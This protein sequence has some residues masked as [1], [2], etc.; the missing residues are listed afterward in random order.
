MADLQS[1]LD[2]VRTIVVRDSNGPAAAALHKGLEAMLALLH[3]VGGGAAGRVWRTA[4]GC[5][6]G[7]VDVWQYGALVG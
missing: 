1:A 5:Q 7:E 6:R 3:G 4:R 2:D